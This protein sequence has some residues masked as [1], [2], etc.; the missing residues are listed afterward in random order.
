MVSIHNIH[1]P[2]RNGQSIDVRIYRFTNEKNTVLPAYV[3]LHEGGY[4]FGLLF[5]EDAHCARI[6]SALN[7]IVISVGYRHTPEFTYLTQHNDAWD[8]SCWIKQNAEKVGIKQDQVA[9]GGISAGAGLAASVV[10]RE[11]KNTLEIPWYK[12]TVLCKT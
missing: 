3:Y 10:F 5:S 7:I 8:V 2:V 9:I 12:G 6:T 1:V 4:L 11:F